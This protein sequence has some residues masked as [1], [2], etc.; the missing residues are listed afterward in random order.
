MY[1]RPTVTLSAR[2]YRWRLDTV[3]NEKALHWNCKTSKACTATNTI[4]LQTYLFWKIGSPLHRIEFWRNRCLAYNCTLCRFQWSWV[5]N[6]KL[7]HKTRII[8]DQ[9]YAFR[10][11]GSNLL[12]SN[13]CTAIRIRSLSVQNTLVISTISRT[14][15]ESKMDES[16]NVSKGLTLRVVN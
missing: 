10:R 14:W 7:L 8:N 13:F 16:V 15:D 11:S 9:C 2:C 3:L 12:T 4:P 1:Y 5:A 6:P